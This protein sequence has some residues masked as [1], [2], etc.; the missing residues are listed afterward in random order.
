M[1]DPRPTYKTVIG[2][3]GESCAFYIADRLG[4]SED[5]DL[6]IIFDPV[7]VRKKRHDMSRKYT[8]ETIVIKEVNK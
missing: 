4:M 3:A 1:F 5:Y 2:E 6:S 7:E 8:D